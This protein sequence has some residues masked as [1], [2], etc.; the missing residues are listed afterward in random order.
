MGQVDRLRDK[1][2]TFAALFWDRGI[3]Y[4]PT[5]DIA[6]LHPRTQSMSLDGHAAGGDLL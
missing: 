1:V 4:L 2:E 5:P 3:V 6:T